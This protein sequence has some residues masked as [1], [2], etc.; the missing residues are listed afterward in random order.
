MHI[1]P[2]PPPGVKAGT[3]SE[4]L[5][6]M[7]Y[8]AGTEASK[9][10][11]N[12]TLVYTGA[13]RHATRANFVARNVRPEV[14]G[15]RAHYTALYVVFESPF[16]MVSDYP[17]AY[18]GQK[19]LD[20]IREVPASWDETRVL[21]AKVGDYVTIARRRGADWYVGSIAGW[22]A[23]DLAIPLNFLGQGQYMADIYSDAP[24]ADEDPTHSTLEHKLVT[25]GTVLK[26]KLVSGGGQAMRIR[27]ASAAEAGAKKH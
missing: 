16:E 9:V 12:A 14:M 13:M 20:F 4:H 2:Y 24:D 22:H 26:A 27:P 15:S 17:E 5:A 7:G 6:A 25:K 3:P 8:T 23:A 21:N 1:Q 19:E 18:N 11:A 10:K